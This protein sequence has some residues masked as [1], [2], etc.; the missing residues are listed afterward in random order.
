MN[1]GLSVL[2]SI[3]FYFIWLIFS[4]RVV[5]SNTPVQ[6]V[7]ADEPAAVSLLEQLN[8]T[9]AVINATLVVSLDSIFSNRYTGRNFPAVIRF[10]NNDPGTS[11]YHLKVEVR[12]KS[13]RR[14]CDMPPLKLN[15]SKKELR[16]DGLLPFDK[17]KLV[18]HCLDA[19]PYAEKLVLKEYLA[20]LLYQHLT[21]YSY[22][23]QLLKLTYQDAYKTDRTMTQWAFLLESDE[24]LEQRLGAKEC[25]TCMGQPTERYEKAHERICALFECMIGNSDWSMEMKRNV[26]FFE[27]ESQTLVAVPYDF[28]FSAF[29]GAPYRRVDANAN[30]NSPVDR[31]FMGNATNARELYSTIS[32]FKTRRQDFVNTISSFEYLP[33]NDRLDLV[34]YLDTFFESVRT[35]EEAEENYFR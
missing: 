27:L 22:R 17:F 1:F 34:Q 19:E 9:G 15:F 13:R 10:E 25:K 8:N 12:G 18:T 14:T 28:D 29:V 4:V 26:T 6:P 32:L 5:A 20:Y 30:R 2:R 24:E 23:V 11:Q 33:K 31:M 16:E 3:P 35:M 7:A 21:P